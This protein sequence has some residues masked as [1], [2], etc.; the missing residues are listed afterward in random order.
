M[1]EVLSNDMPDVQFGAMLKT[2]QN[3]LGYRR[4]HVWGQGQTVYKP[5]WWWTVNVFTNYTASDLARTYEDFWKSHQ[6]LFVE[7]IDNR[8]RDK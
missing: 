3:V 6:I 1:W 2:N 4:V 7:S 5:G 8:G